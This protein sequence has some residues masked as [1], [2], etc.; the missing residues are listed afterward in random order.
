M[1]EFLDL[2]AELPSKE[3]YA[4]EALLNELGIKLDAEEKIWE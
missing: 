2:L 1:P 3:D 4:V